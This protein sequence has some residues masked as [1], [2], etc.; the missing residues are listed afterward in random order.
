L[1]LAALLVHAEGAAHGDLQ[2]VFGAEPGAALLL[3]EE[4]AADLGAII[5]QGEVEV[6]GLGFAAVGDF[7]LNKDVGEVPGEQVAN[8]GGEFAYGEN[9]ASG[10]KVEGELAHCEWLVF[11]SQFPGGKRKVE[12]W[13]M[14]RAPK[15]QRSVARV[16]HGK[17][18]TRGGGKW[19]EYPHTP[20][21]SVGVRNKG[22]RAYAK[23]LLFAAAFCRDGKDVFESRSVHGKWDRALAIKNDAKNRTGLG[24]ADLS[25]QGKGMSG[26]LTTRLGKTLA[27]L[28][29]SCGN[30]KGVTARKL[31]SP[32]PWL[33]D[34]VD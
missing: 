7:A 20:A 21:V 1:I 34:A 18:H 5:L 14:G 27:L 13:K 31:E 23:W 32:S 30:W 9:L 8:A 26:N 24:L 4:N 3:F 12:K 28:F 16:A 15:Q 2:A 25:A 10:L 17:K 19:E 29:D 22:L 6:A 33:R 11:S